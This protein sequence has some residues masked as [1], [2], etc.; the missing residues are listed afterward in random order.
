MVGG[1]VSSFPSATSL[2]H[3]SS[4]LVEFIGPP[5]FGAGGGVEGRCRYLDGVLYSLS[6]HVSPF[7]EVF[8]CGVLAEVR[9]VYLTGLGQVQQGGCEC[10]PVRLFP[11]KTFSGWGS[12]YIWVEGLDL[13]AY[14]FVIRARGVVFVNGLVRHLPGHSWGSDREIKD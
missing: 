14:D 8:V 12:F 2:G 11:I 9:P 4:C 7:V 3:G 1:E 10:F 13:E 6:E 5:P